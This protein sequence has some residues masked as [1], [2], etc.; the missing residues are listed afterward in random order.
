MRALKSFEEY[1]SSND[2]AWGK[3][4]YPDNLARWF[5]VFRR[6]QVLV[7][8]FDQLIKK[9]LRL[10]DVVAQHFELSRNFSSEVK[11]PKT[12]AA[13]KDPTLEAQLLCSTV[14]FLEANQL[15][16]QK[17]KLYKLLSENTQQN[18]KSALEP[19]FGMFQRAS[20]VDSMAVL[21]D[22]IT[23]EAFEKEKYAHAEL[24]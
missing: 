7:L 5:N 19:E 21:T 24:G 11:L 22:E 15:K 2:L 23:E 1:I 17:E 10:I 13:S 4:N 3:S 12:N 6:Q 16:G 8:N 14:D 18:P 20:C 9:D